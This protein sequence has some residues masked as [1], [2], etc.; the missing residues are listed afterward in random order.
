MKIKFTLNIGNYQNIGFETND[1]ETIIECYEEVLT[2]L[3]HWRSITDNG[4]KAYNRM[5]QIV[6]RAE[7]ENYDPTPF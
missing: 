4:E 3:S 2:F 1:C 6:S 7:E 5:N